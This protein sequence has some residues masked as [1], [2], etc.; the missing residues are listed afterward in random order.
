MQKNILI[1]LTILLVIYFYFNYNDDTVYVKS[2]IDNNMYKILKGKNKNEEFLKASANILGLINVRIEILIKHLEKEYSSSD[3]YYFIKM[4]KRNYHHSIL[5]EAHID[6][7]YT[8]FTVNKK[9]MKVCIRTRS[10]DESLYDINLLIYILLHEL[11]HLINYDRNG[12]PIGGDESHG[13]HFR[14]IFAFLVKEAIKI[15]I[16]KYEDYRVNNTEYCGI[17]VN[18]SII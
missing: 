7:R 13:Q 4:L 9:L 1:I 2:D 8:T 14:M 17:M 18:S 5:Q 12:Y 3:Y 15:G 10:K 16:Y 6:K 11:S